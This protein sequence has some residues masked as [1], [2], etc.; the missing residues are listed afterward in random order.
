MSGDPCICGDTET[1][2]PECYQKQREEAQAAVI[3]KARAEGRIDGLR[4]SAEIAQNHEGSDCYCHSIIAD[5]I[6]A[7]IPSPVPDSATKRCEWEKRPRP[8]GEMMWHSSCGYVW[9]WDSNAAV[10]ICGKPA[11]RVPE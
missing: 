9:A 3:A 11:Y 4:E 5:R 8:S 6:L 10:C 1:W 2:H 7:A